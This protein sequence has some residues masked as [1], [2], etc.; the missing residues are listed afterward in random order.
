MADSGQDTAIFITGGAGFIGTNLIKYLLG[1]TDFVVTVYDNLSTGSK[2][3]LER[4]SKDASANPDRIKLIQ[5]DILD[6]QKLEQSIP[7]HFAV[8]H[9]A[10]HTRVLESVNNPGPSLSLNTAGTFNVIEAARVNKVKCFIFASS[11]AA[12]GRQS[13]PVNE[14]MLPC[15]ISP[16][17]AA[18]LFGESL[19]TAYYHSYGLPTVALRFANAY[20]PYSENK[21][22]VITKF[23]KESISGKQLEIYGDGNQSRDFVHAADLAAAITAIIKIPPENKECFGQI[24]QIA[25]AKET[26]IIDLAKTITQLTGQNQKFDFELPRPG[27]IFRNF[28]D[29]SKAKKIFNYKPTHVLEQELPKLCEYFRVN[30]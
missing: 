22:S 9:L 6:R 30:S 24:F 18:K 1:N 2:Q 21:T 17:G 10:A 11:N 27:E 8:V 3:N 15:P 29:I 25:T 28:S 20:G 7:G 5:A 26:K 4:A 16:Y 19:C 23:I 13:P 12:V 14:K